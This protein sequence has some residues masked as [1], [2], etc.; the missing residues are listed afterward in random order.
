MRQRASD[1]PG[2]YKGDLA[3]HYNYEMIKAKVAFNHMYAFKKK[4][5]QSYVVS[6]ADMSHLD[7]PINEMMFLMPQFKILDKFKSED[8]YNYMKPHF[9]AVLTKAPKE[10]WSL[11]KI[12]K[13]ISIKMDV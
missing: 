6:N 5:K 8:N 7:F 11:I 13:V 12:K 3:K 4:P 2:L 9:Q 1:P 10:I